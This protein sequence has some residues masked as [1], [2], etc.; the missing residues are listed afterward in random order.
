VSGRRF[1]ESVVED[2]ALAWLESLGYAVKHGPDITAGGETLTLTQSERESYS[3][4]V[5]AERLRQ[6]LTRPNPTLP[7]EAID[8][9]FRKVS[10]LEGAMLDARNG[11]SSAAR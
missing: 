6:A 10:R 8:D 11:V 7:S 9:A 2:A 5:L 3:Q 1:T 4:V